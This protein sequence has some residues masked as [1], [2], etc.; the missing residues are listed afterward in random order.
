LEWA[1]TTAQP[2][3]GIF[4]DDSPQ[5]L[6][7]KFLSLGMMVEIMLIQLGKALPV[8]NF[9]RTQLSSPPEPQGA[10]LSVVQ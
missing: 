8:E 5:V 1:G 10:H 2:G 4:I 9:Y 3:L 6:G 7:N